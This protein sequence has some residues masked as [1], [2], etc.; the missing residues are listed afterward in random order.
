M[1]TNMRV[2]AGA[3]TILAGSIY[4]ADSQHIKPHTAED[5]EKILGF[6]YDN[7]PGYFKPIR[8]FQAQYVPI[9]LTVAFDSQSRAIV[10]SGKQRS[11][12]FHDR[13]GGVSVYG[14]GIEYIEHSGDAGVCYE[15]GALHLASRDG[16]LHRLATD[17]KSAACAGPLFCMAVTKDKLFLGAGNDTITCVS[18]DSFWGH[19]K[20][21]YTGT[22]SGWVNALEVVDN[23][24]ISGNYTGEVALIDI[25]TGA[26]TAVGNHDGH[27]V[28][29]FAKFGNIVYSGAQ[30]IAPQNNTHS[31]SSTSSTSSTTSTCSSTGCHY[32]GS[33]A[34]E[35]NDAAAEI[36]VWDVR[37]AK[38]VCGF[39]DGTGVNAM[40]SLHKGYLAVGRKKGMITLYDMR[41]LQAAETLCARYGDNYGSIT[42]LTTT[43]DGG[44]IS[45]NSNSLIHVWKEK[46]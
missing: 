43:D 1:N 45:T 15:S 24:L 8:I 35:T 40:V 14:V 16:K 34:P 5:T 44:I 32:I 19:V 23:K 25:E 33:D 46:Q 6:K 22:A 31:A 11:A 20:T 18:N 38:S 12:R 4:A 36:K 9:S 37:T 27:P 29:A 39:T 13:A 42:A 21:S 7:G 10:V 3:A 26:R 41:T 2:V 17:R 30:F 28:T